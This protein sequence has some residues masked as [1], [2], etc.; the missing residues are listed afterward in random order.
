MTVRC[1][2]MSDLHNEFELRK[3]NPGPDVSRLKG[4]VDIVLLAGDIDISDKAVDYANRLYEEL[5][6]EVILVAG[7]HEFYHANRS[8]VLRE[9]R[10]AAGNSPVHFLDNDAAYLEIR[11]IKV[12]VLGCTLWTDYELHG[13]KTCAPS[14]MSEIADQL[15]DH[16]IIYET[17]KRTFSPDDALKVH[18]ESRAWLVTEFSK[19]FSG[20]TVVMTHHAPSEK[21]VPARFLND[22]ITPAFAS[23]LDK[24]VEQSGAALWVH[25]HTHDSFDYFIGSTRVV[26]N[27][28]GYVSRELNVKFDPEKIIDI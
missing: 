24:L 26:C 12:R 10:R 2:V 28:R 14:V 11:N 13:A 18:E 16:Y 23:N 9:L 4:N 19:M 7:N 21:S 27:P 25:G 8:R 3:Q 5:Q 1:L 15:N 20:L 17:E 6:C 22:L